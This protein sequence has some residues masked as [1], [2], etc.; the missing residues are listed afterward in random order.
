MTYIGLELETILDVSPQGGIGNYSGAGR[1][2][3]E[4]DPI[5]GTCWGAKEDSSINPRSGEL[6]CEFVTPKLLFNAAW[7]GDIF[8]TVGQMR[9]GVLQ[10]RTNAS[11]G[12]HISLSSPRMSSQQLYNLIYLWREYQQAFMACTASEN[13]ARGN[14][15]TPYTT[16][17][18]INPECI[19]DSDALSNC[20]NIL[21]RC[22]NMNI[23]H[24]N[25]ARRYVPEGQRIEFRVFSGTVNPRKI[26]A[27]SNLA[28]CFMHWATGDNPR[29]IL[30]MRL[31]VGEGAGMRA[32]N[33]LLDNLG[34]T[35]R[36]RRRWTPSYI[37]HALQ[38]RR[39]SVN[40]LRECANRYDIKAQRRNG[41]E[42]M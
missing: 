11:C 35:D 19:G 34:W 26:V 24:M 22:K 12:C 37:S 15:C 41:G 10:A 1:P 8:N 18:A 33:N 30:P 32:L 40:V 5:C 27:W 38:T 23:S 2:V 4:L 17:P 16:L 7:I 42:V 21:D 3:E 25:L 28:Y 36:G 9:D 29:P 13:R 39:T 31:E 14:Y 6:G 20:H